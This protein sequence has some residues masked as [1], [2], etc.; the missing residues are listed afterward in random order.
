MELRLKETKRVNPSL[1]V[2]NEVLLYAD[3]NVEANTGSL[4]VGS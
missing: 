4:S 1:C 2:R 3:G